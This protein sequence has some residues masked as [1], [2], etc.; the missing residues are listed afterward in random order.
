MTC[1]LIATPP[2][3]RDLRLSDEMREAVIAAITAPTKN[4]KAKV[5]ASVAARAVA[6]R[7]SLG[8]V[9]GALSAGEIQLLGE[10]LDRIAEPGA[11]P[12]STSTTASTGRRSEKGIA[13]P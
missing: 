9:E 2:G 4:A 7:A 3:E 12:R 5:G 1:S 13:G 8:E 6:L 10:W 11:H